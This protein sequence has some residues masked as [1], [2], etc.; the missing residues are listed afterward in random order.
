MH[1]SFD[2]DEFYESLDA[3]SVT[4]LMESLGDYVAQLF[5]REEVQEV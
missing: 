3:S 5:G 2:R 4:A 1:K